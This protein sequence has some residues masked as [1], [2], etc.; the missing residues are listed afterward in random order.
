MYC[1]RCGKQLDDA[2][3][4][5]N[6]CGAQL[7]SSGDAQGQRS[8]LNTLIVALIVIVTGGI[9]VLAGLLAILL[10]RV[11]NFEP[12]MA[13]SMFY[14]GTLF[15]ICFLIMRQVSKLI[16]AKLAGKNIYDPSPAKTTDT[17]QPLVQLPPRTTAQLEEHRQPASVVDVTTRTLEE[18]PVSRRN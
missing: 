10:E 9:G 17:V 4:F 12:V 8:I 6:G 5:C 1:D 7:R 13:F 18:V 16:D 11:P 3:N 15:A 2:L 14:L